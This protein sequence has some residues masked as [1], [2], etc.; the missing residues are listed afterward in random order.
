MTDS[1]EPTSDAGIAEKSKALSDILIELIGSAI[2][3]YTL[4]ILREY[5]DIIKSKQA[6]I[7]SLCETGAEVPEDAAALYAEILRLKAEIAGPD[8]Y[9]TWKDAAVAERTNKVGL[10]HKNKELLSEI[11]KVNA[12][13]SEMVTENKRLSSDNT[14]LRTKRFARFNNEDCWIYDSEMD[15]HLE[16]LV[17][18]VVISPQKLMEFERLLRPVG[19]V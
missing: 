14:E 6:L 18:P 11:S 4:S 3:E 16:S 19:G 8:G 1:K 7:D 12:R 9:T 10:E 2:N 5:T 17:C 13:Y 15:N